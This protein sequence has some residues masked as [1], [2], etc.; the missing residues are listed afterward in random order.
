MR[1]LFLTN[2]ILASTGFLISNPGP[3]PLLGALLFRADARLAEIAREEK[4][5]SV[6]QAFFAAVLP[7]QRQLHDVPFLRGGL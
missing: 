4:V 7:R 3:D 2:S 1:V 6:D 5:A